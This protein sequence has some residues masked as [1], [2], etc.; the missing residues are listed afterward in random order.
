MNYKEK[1]D[2]ELRKNARSFP[3][4]RLIITAGNS[5]QDLS[6]QFTKVPEGIA[7]EVIET[8]GY[9]GLP[10]KTTVFSPASGGDNM[11]ALVY[12]HGGAFVYKAAAYQK[13]LACIYAEKAECKVFFPHYHLAPGYKYPAAYRDVMS[14]YKYVVSH[15]EELG[16]DRERI[17]IAGDSAGASIAALVCNRCKEEKTQTPCVQMLVYP[18]TDADM[19]TDSMKRFLDTPQ[20]DSRSNK[21]MWHYYCGNSRERRYSASPM[22]CDLPDSVP[23]TYIETTEFDCLRDEGIL[24][25]KKLIDAGNTVTINE[26]EG[27]FHGYDSASDAQIVIRN[28]DIRTAF[29]S[30]GFRTKGGTKNG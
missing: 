23:E 27:T 2:P 16:V 21:R 9:Q 22:H 14:L 3:F 6:W 15:A 13:K 19:D 12:V 25:G 1:V 8:E 24:Y 7:E 11:P 17:G 28:V 29:L 30:N 4:N 10:L 26:T 18:V 5:Y 20:W